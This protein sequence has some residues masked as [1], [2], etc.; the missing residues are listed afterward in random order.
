MG[1]KLIALAQCFVSQ[2]SAIAKARSL[3][4]NLVFCL[5]WR[6]GR[7][8]AV[9]TG[10]DRVA[11]NGDAANKIGTSMVATLARRY[12][13]PFYIAGPVSTIDMNTPTGDDI[14]LKSEVRK[15]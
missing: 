7:I 13:I 11:A 2:V 14:R 10:C 12:N 4:E 5:A 8:N 6:E 9:F 3:T 15:K 1:G